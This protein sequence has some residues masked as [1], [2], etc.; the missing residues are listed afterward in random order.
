MYKKN[1]FTILARPLFTRV[2]ILMLLIV[3][4]ASL[5]SGAFSLSVFA[6]EISDGSEGGFPEGFDYEFSE[7][8]GDENG[9]VFS[10]G[11]GDENGDVFS[12]ESG[13]ENSDVFSAESGDE[14]INEFSGGSEEDVSDESVFESAKD[15]GNGSGEGTTSTASDVTAENAGHVASL[16]SYLMNTT[17]D[18]SA[19][20]GGFPW[21]SEQKQRSWTYYNGIMMDA[22]LM[23][24]FD[25]YFEDVNN[26]YQYNITESGQVDSTDALENSYREDEL[27]SIPPARA[28]FDLLR[29]KEGELPPD[30]DQKY[31]KLIINI[32][33]IMRKF[34]TIPDAGNN[35][36]HKMGNENWETY[37][38][39][40]DGLY[41]ALPFFMEVANALDN[42]NFQSGDFV[43]SSPPNPPDQNQIYKEVAERMLWVGENLYDSY[44]C[45]YYHG[46]GPQAGPNQQYWLRAVGWYA[47][48]LADIISMMPDGEDDGSNEELHSYKNRLIENEKKLF[49][50]MMKYQDS[51][52]GMW[53][54]V[55]NFGR[56]LT[57]STGNKNRLETSGSALM[58]YAMMKSYVE[59]YVGDEYG[60]AGLRAFN[61]VVMNDLEISGGEYFLH[62]VYQSSGVE[63]SPEGYLKKPYVDNEAKGVGPLIMA[64][65]YAKEAAR[66]H[67]NPESYT[68][69]GT[70]DKTLLLNEVPDF[71]N[72]ELSLHFDNGSDR[73]ITKDELIFEE[74]EDYDPAEP[75]TYTVTVSY[76]GIEYGTIQVTF[77]LPQPTF[78]SHSLVLTGEIGVN[79]YM[80]LPGDPA[81]YEDSYMTFS[82][83]GLDADPVYPDPGFMNDSGWYGFTCYVNT[84]QMAEKITAV[85]HYGEDNAETVEDTYSVL[86]YL[87]NANSYYAQ[88]K[89]SQEAAQAASALK[90]Y[91]YFAQQ[92]LS[93]IHG[94]SLG[95]G[96][97][98]TGIPELGYYPFTQFDLDTAL[99][100][101]EDRL[102]TVKPGENVE[103]LAGLSY[104]LVLDSDTTVNIYYR[105][106]DENGEYLSYS[107]HGENFEPQD[108]SDTAEKLS[109]GRYL[110]SVRNIPAHLLDDG[111]SITI[112][113]DLVELHLRAVSY[114]FDV[115]SKDS[116]P[117]DMKFAM[118]SIIKYCE[119]VKKYRDFLQN[120]TQ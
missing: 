66:I 21:D 75:G 71:S 40:L 114:A 45:L 50:G 100:G 43:N 6:D 65:T 2:I 1:L 118:L 101:K 19:R 20:N 106:N 78:E 109:D 113:G 68:L 58:A 99:D 52:T 38:F 3:L 96:G 4:P 116:Y 15:A 120:S 108:F 46:W 42:G 11:S 112:G 92:Y 49:Y 24:D 81:Y 13:D 31:K 37:Q 79:F 102:C 17:V 27:D 18:K 82:C 89:I 56:E 25:T 104:S 34:E 51:D 117:N 111:F 115:L 44:S 30:C 87:N 103:A 53:Y 85:F 107:F 41:M 12:V 61:G 9:D 14:N 5:L 59:G 84:L 16:A 8:S 63:T 7:G 39:A 55:I 60:E 22:F 69:S 62:N 32:Y 93:R 77:E 72:V 29:N 33:N 98:Y 67:N 74:S 26:F 94:F 28:L 90:E 97:K 70:E 10:V 36:K 47:A 95:E 91:G 86:E 48:A 88:D 64:S 119:D 105:L 83:T 110:I 73:L 80:N 54:N 23:L 76:N 35:F 57:G